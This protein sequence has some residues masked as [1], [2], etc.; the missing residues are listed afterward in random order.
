MKPSITSLLLPL[1][2]CSFAFAKT[3]RPNILFIYTD[4]QSHRT[5]GCYPESYDWV[6]TPNINALARAGV[7]FNRAYIGSW[8]MP[9]RATLLTG[10]HQHGIESMR[11]EGQY[12]GSAYDPEKCPFWPSVFR[13]EGYTTAHIGKWHTG[14]DTGYGRDWDYQIVWNRPKF[15]KN[16]PNYYDDQIIVKNGGPPKRVQGYTT[17]KYTDWA[18]DFIN[19]EGRPSE[20]PWYLWLCYGAVHGPFTPAARHVGDYADGHVLAPADVYPPRDGKPEYVR[21]MEFWEPGKD[22]RP[23][24]R[25]V[26]KNAPVGM[27]DSPGRL[28]SD[29]VH[30][31]HEG[32][33]AID[34]NVGR[35]LETLKSSGQD[36]NTLVVYTSDQGFAW[37]QHGFK[38]KVAPYDAT[39]AC[40]LIIRPPAKDAASSAGRVIED[41][42]SGVDLPPTFF[43]FAGIDVPWKMHGH[44]LSP[45][46]QAES[47]TWNHPAMLVHT[48]KQ[49]GSNTH[50]I[51]KADDPDLYHGPGIPWYVMLSKGEFKYVRNLID[52]EVEELYDLNNDPD[53]LNNLALLP[54][55]GDHLR[56]FRA[57]AMNELKRT[58]AEMVH[59]LPSVGTPD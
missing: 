33:L 38:S 10:H 11:M 50:T 22:G 26:R 58:D 5:V 28:L 3:E 20:K 36:S 40:P 13:K 44:D 2:M 25:Q 35:L 4:D 29:W 21:K 37:G 9:S 41:P 42:V 59:S 34:E 57:A 45:L 53:E 55:H 24:E 32:V 52:G 48:A 15:P 54:E 39:V 47:A 18:I 51:P 46:L 31:Y 16:S 56:K 30:Q 19:G 17:D 7:R 6:R 43:S 27:K 49:Y 23:V 1:A 12:P 8:C 14:V